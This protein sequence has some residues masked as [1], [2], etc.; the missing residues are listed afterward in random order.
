MKIFRSRLAV[1]VVPMFASAVLSS[2]V[3]PGYEDDGRRTSYVGGP[4]VYT[5]L[6][7][8][9]VGSVY[10]YQGR[11]YS[12]GAY[13]TGR[14]QEQGRSY[15]SRYY[16]NGQY[17]YGG[18]HQQHGSRGGQVD[19]RRDDRRD[20]RDSWRDRDERGNDANR[21]GNPNTSHGMRR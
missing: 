21:F 9:H 8:N 2:C 19:P 4:R 12:G 14:Y 18:N 1:M 5:S 6:P 15:N 13:Q 20:P 16:Y 3:I 7:S 10:Y 17:L 11:Y